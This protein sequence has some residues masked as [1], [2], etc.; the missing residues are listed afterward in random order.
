MLMAANYQRFTHGICATH[1]MP[2][3]GTLC[4]VGTCILHSVAQYQ[5]VG[6]QIKVVQKFCMER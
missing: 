5:T 3:E 1:D 6:R 2:R 4:E